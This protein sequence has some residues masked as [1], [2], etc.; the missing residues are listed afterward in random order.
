MKGFNHEEAAKK[1]SGSW[2][3]GADA[4]LVLDRR[5]AFIAGIEWAL[6]TYS[7]I[8]FKEGAESAQNENSDYAKRKS[9]GNKS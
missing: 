5:A 8:I 2:M 4:Q 3:N 7:E 1:Y 6:T 9:Q